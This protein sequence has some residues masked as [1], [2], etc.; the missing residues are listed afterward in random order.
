MISEIYRVLSANGV[1][2]LVSAGA[3]EFRNPYLERPEYDWKIQVVEVPKPTIAAQI[4]EPNTDKDIPNVHYIYT[5]SKGKKNELP[6]VAPEPVVV[7]TTGVPAP[8]KTWY[9]MVRNNIVRLVN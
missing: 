8:A 2:I 9:G 1:Y 5:C 7:P 3:P 6:V 4:T